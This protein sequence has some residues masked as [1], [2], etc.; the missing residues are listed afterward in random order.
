MTDTDKISADLNAR[1]AKKLP[2]YY[3][4]RLIFWHDE[5]REFKERLDEIHLENA[6]LI[7]LDETN[8]FY[9]KRMITA[10][11]TTHNYCIYTPLRYE[12]PDDNWLYGLEMYSEEY[13]SD[14]IAIWI[15]EMKWEQSMEI[16]TA[17]KQYRTFFKAKERRGAVMAFNKPTSRRAVGTVIVAALCKVKKPQTDKIVA[18]VLKNPDLMDSL[19]QYGV[20]DVFWESTAGVCGCREKN[21][22]ALA[23]CIFLTAA[24]RY[25]PQ[26]MFSEADA[27]D[28]DEVYAPWCCA[29]VSD[30]GDQFYDKVREIEAEIALIDK[31]SKFSPEEV[32]Q[33]DVFPA[34]D[35][36]ILL[37]FMKQIA[38]DMI[39]DRAIKQVVQMRRNTTWYE[40]Y[41]YLYDGLDEVA[42]MR[43]FYRENADSFHITEAE[44]F[45]NTYTEKYYKM[46][47]Y[48]R[49]FQV[50]YQKSLLASDEGLEDYFK[51]V[52]DVAERQYKDWFLKE[53]SEAWTRVAE[54]D[55]RDLGY[56]NGVEKQVDFYRDKVGNSD[57]KVYV[58]ISDALRY[59]VGVALNE[60]LKSERAKVS[61]EARQAIFPTVTKYGM[62][63]LLPHKMM[64]VCQGKKGDL[65]VLC[66]TMT[67][68]SLNRTTVLQ[69]KNAKS[70]AIKYSDYMGAKNRDA[71]REM[72]GGKDVV[73]IYHDTID[74]A[75]HND[76]STLFDACEK[77]VDE[78]VALVRSLVSSVSATQI[79]ITADHGFLYTESPLR[80]SDKIAGIEKAV[81]SER[82]YVI[83][84]NPISGEKFTSLL[85][86][87]FFDENFFA[88]TPRENIRFMKKGS[89]ENF[90]HGGISL[91][92]IVIPVIKFTSLRRQSKEV[93]NN[94]SKYEK[95][96]VGLTLAMPV[97]LRPIRNRLF[98]LRFSQS[99]LV[100]GRCEACQYKIYFE[101]KTGKLVSTVQSFVA[102]KKDDVYHKMSFT[103][104]GQFNRDETY[105]LVIENAAN[106]KREKTAYCVDIL[107]SDD[108]DF[109]L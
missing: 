63:A 21:L 103:L 82:R 90:V 40:K 39:D 74:A 54:D 12:K 34:I 66:D 75:G 26:G 22:Y 68:E 41:A 37:T 19:E 14:I 92:E 99:E 25:L 93:K 83:S 24:A 97:P 98:S 32:A 52:K 67:T 5:E 23:R 51:S 13:R 73:Y 8:T 31:L 15:E 3:T 101:D 50:S 95:H 84:E 72:V 33:S 56:I 45:F 79:Y 109:D 17:V 64:T 44:K 38:Q 102:D 105:Y 78:L 59:E 57:T 69:Q 77:T 86:V 11:D 7:A 6:T 18:A 108:F 85:S 81:E 16:R 2:E 28:I 9:V 46:D 87:K 104:K 53:L 55:M 27:S 60:R 89:S 80:E 43:C 42:N 48:Y 61:L 107:G 4:R 62:A 36:Y 30:F 91:Q 70:I 49:R 47:T 88:A 58:I 100:G 71:Q 76:D 96:P 94:V 10:D 1:F 29:F 20:I 106:G 35:E 65:Q